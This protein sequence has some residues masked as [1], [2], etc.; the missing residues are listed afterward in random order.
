MGFYPISEILEIIGWILINTGILSMIFNPRMLQT[1][2]F[3]CQR[4]SGS[5]EGFLL[6][7]GILS[8]I[9]NPQILPENSTNDAS[10]IPR[11][12]RLCGEF[13]FVG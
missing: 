8:L 5:L 12:L 10:Q 7:T 1:D 2:S 6:N 11:L 3:D 4:F 9:S 13:F